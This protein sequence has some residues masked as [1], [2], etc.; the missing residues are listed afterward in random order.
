MVFEN[1]TASLGL[2]NILALLAVVV[3]GLPHGAFDGAI[4][5]Q[6]GFS[7]RPYF[8]CRFLLYY[9]LMTLL[10]V[11]L[12]FLFPIISL[13]VFLLI[14]ALHFGFGDARSE[15]GWFRWVQVIAHGG[16]VVAGISQFH[17]LEVDKIFNYI[18]GQDT[19]VVWL[20]MDLTTILVVTC[21]VIYGCQALW[22]Q[23][24]RL[25]FM[26]LNLLLFTLFLFSPLVGFALYF[27]CIH[28][29]RHLLCLRRF[30]QETTQSNYFYIQAISFTIASWFF[31]GFVYWCLYEQ[32]P[33]ETAL[34][35]VIFI[36][37]AALTVPHMILVDGFLKKHLKVV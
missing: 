2:F 28:S 9:V 8:L 16:G 22:D 29:V 15:R 7:N 24:W 31:G 13:I 36:G 23:R 25:G 19:S 11:V 37:L 3:I 32:V 10:V 5:V 14:S 34:L 18:T 27:C 35:R 33:V 17:K 26:E 30:L 1:L 12:W 21:F 20:A 6:L 4:A